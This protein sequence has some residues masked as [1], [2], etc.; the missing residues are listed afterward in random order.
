MCKVV[1]I[2]LSFDN[3]PAEDSPVSHFSMK[4]LQI[5]TQVRE[6]G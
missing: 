5:E 6:Q 1:A 3:N 2:N 4:V